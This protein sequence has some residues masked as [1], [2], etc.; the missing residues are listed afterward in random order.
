MLIGLTEFLPELYLSLFDI[1]EL[2]IR[3][4]VS[5]LFGILIGWERARRLKDAGVRTHC[6]IAVT[7]AA[8]MIISKYAFL[9][10]ESIK[11]ADPARLA[12]QVVSGISFLGAGVIF[13]GK[14]DSVKGLTTAA[15]MWATAAVGMAI[16]AGLYWVGIFEAAAVIAG[17]MV[18]HKFP[19]G[20][21]ALVVQEMHVVID[22]DEESE[23]II[24]Q[25]IKKHGGNIEQS[26]ITREG[27][28]LDIRLSARLR[29]PISL[30]ECIALL[31]RYQSIYKMHV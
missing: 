19:V 7:S 25:L 27:G 15:G 12:A 16:G 13:R 17:Q 21:D 2:L 31:S 3:I 22:N 29:E 11:S 4:C 5:A 8:F 18:L 28:K 26:E 9:D 6:I 23:E 30:E 1:L 24:N 20:N 14:N 10:V